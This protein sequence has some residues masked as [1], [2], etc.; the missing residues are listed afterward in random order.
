MA[1]VF[2]AVAEQNQWQAAVQ[3]KTPGGPKRAQETTKGLLRV[4]PCWTRGRR[5]TEERRAGC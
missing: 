1:C 4:L 5:R 2:S 3:G